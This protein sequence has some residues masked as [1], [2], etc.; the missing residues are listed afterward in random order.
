MGKTHGLES[1]VGW[2][3]LLAGEKK[4]RGKVEGRRGSKKFFLP[5]LIPHHF[6]FDSSVEKLCGCQA[7]WKQVV[8]NGD[9]GK[10]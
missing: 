2:F 8:A 5:S 9:Y 6:F 1:A 10:E 3:L 4:K 7:P